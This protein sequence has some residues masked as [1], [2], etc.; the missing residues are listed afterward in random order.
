MAS[1]PRALSGCAGAPTRQ[2]AR[3]VPVR[4]GGFP[5]EDLCQHLQFKT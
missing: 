3:M 4:L 1:I 5:C 2:F